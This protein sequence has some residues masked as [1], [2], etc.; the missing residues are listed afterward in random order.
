MQAARDVSPV[1]AVSERV[2]PP[3][4]AAKERLRTWGT[5][6][7]RNEVNAAKLRLPTLRSIHL[8]R[9]SACGIADLSGLKEDSC[10]TGPSYS[11]SVELPGG[12]FSNRV[13]HPCAGSRRVGYPF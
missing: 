11:L 2:A 6:A 4:L 7:F 9:S 13:A 1:G 5:K 12:L 10:R 8:S 3:R